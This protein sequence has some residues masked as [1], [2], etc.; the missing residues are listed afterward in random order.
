LE[1][2]KSLAPDNASDLSE[3]YLNIGIAYDDYGKPDKA[4]ENY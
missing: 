1:L 3:T 4:L 2:Q